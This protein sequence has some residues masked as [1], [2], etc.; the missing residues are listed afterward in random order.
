MINSGN[1]YAEM[2]FNAMIHQIK[3]EIGA[4]CAVLDGDVDAIILTAGVSYD[5]GF[6]E[7]IRKSLSFIAPV[8]AMPGEFE[9]EALAMGA[10]KVLTGEEE[11]KVYTGISPV[12]QE[13]FGE[14]IY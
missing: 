2:I 1:K 4:M 7:S 5:T 11:A 9:M 12:N 6:V 10:L 8:V 13:W 3:K 14:A